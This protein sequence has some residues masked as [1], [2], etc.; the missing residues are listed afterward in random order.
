LRDG[1]L[2]PLVVDDIGNVKGVI[3][4]GQDGVREEYDFEATDLVA[5]AGM[6]KQKT[7]WLPWNYRWEFYDRITVK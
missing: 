7:G 2:V 1:R 3:I 6:R 5:L 4:G